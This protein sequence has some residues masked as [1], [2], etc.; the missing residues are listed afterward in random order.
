M[1]MVLW[2]D[3]NTFASNLI[4]KVFKKKNLTFYSLEAPKDFAYLV[5]DLKPSIIVLDSE[6]A[7]THLD[8]LKVQFDSSANIQQS[9][10]IV[11]GKSDDLG[12][13]N[14]AGHL[15]KPLDPFTVPEQIQKIMGNLN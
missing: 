6:T 14:I 2:I 9:S 3:Q 7:M 10:F 1:G 13:L 11:I 5:E 4:E 12:F 8:A 15:K